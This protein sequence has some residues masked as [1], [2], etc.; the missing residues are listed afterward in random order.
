MDG[1]A[2][3]EQAKREIAKTMRQRLLVDQMLVWVQGK[4]WP[5][6]RTQRHDVKH[7]PTP[8]TTLIIGIVQV[9]VHGGDATQTSTDHDQVDESCI[10]V[11]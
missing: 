8:H 3:P 5:Q 9:Q 6:R 2:A 7:A 1:I 11:K 10:G 4:D